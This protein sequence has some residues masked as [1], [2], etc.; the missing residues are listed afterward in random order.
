MSKKLIVGLGN[1][2]ASY[3]RTRHNLGSRVVQALAA[4]EGVAF[5]EK[6]AFHTLLADLRIGEEQ[7][8]LSLPTT[9]MND[10]GRAVQA[11]VSYFHIPLTDILLIQDEMDFPFNTFAFR[12][13][14]ADGGHQGIASIY[15]LTNTTTFARLRMGIGRPSDQMSSADY[16]LQSFSTEEQTQMP[17]LISRALKAVDNWR[18]DGLTKTMNLW[19]GVKHDADAKSSSTASPS[20]GSDRLL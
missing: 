2:G 20:L 10:S 8:L 9:Y 16:V 13:N 18:I 1:P 3:T 15:A 11:L 12:E 17:L 5:T 4:R 7:V 6:K 19:N 14:G